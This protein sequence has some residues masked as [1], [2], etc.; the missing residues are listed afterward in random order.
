MTR[1]THELTLNNEIDEVFSFISN[2]VNNPVW[3]TSILETDKC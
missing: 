3:D 1:F 2:P